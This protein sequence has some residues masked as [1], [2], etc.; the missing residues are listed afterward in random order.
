MASHS[1]QALS[2]FLGYASI[3][4]WLGAQFPQVL[5]NARRQSVDGLA[6]PF[7]LN[8]LLGDVTN[9][10]GCVLT[11]QLPFQTWLATYFCFVDCTLLGQYFYYRS[12]IKPSP[13][14]YLHSRSRAGS[15]V[16]TT[17][18][19][20]SAERT[21]YRAL[22]SIA[23]DLATEA[24]LAAHRPHADFYDEDDDAVDEDA[25]A[26]LADSFTSDGG[27]SVR[28]AS[29]RRK[30][31]SWG[32]GGAVPDAYP[33]PAPSRR[34]SGSL[35]TSAAASRQATRSPPAR[36]HAA[37]LHMT[38]A[39]PEAEG[40]EAL[41]ARGRSLSRPRAEA[42]EGDRDEWASARPP[43]GSSRASRKGATMVFMGVWALVGVGTL[44]GVGRGVAEA[45]LAAHTGRVLARADAVMP[46]VVPVAFAEAA[47]PYL[48]PPPN[49]H[50]DPSLVFDG[51]MYREDPEEEP[52]LEHVIGRISAWTCTTLYLTS[53][54]PQI[55]KNFVR[56]SVEGLSMYLFI[57]A[58]LGNFFYVAS[59]LTSPK[60]AQA[61]PLAS[62]YLRESIPYL[63]GSGGTLMFDVTIVTQSWLYRP[64]PHPRGRRSTRTLHEE[65]A[66]LLAADATGADD[67]ITPSRRRAG[68]S[69]SSDLM[70]E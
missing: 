47:N 62:A 19:R 24:A 30:T 27:R 29:A 51:S 44:A 11:R 41:A 31:V 64:S 40:A 65:E 2:D 17:A 8:W 14:P 20:L 60:L 7:L 53:R 50:A 32:A 45:G 38:Q 5:E 49:V 58:F 43:R 56:K 18:R 48:S 39:A 57:F 25:L 54:L 35:G 52:S 55:W 16:A 26:R 36:I 67:A 46:E 63:L 68:V 42:E 12:S 4:C 22:S 15:L 10:I 13:S 70:G 1:S 21:H 66:G 69:G 33:A 37:A 34:R 28:S 59:I 61:A 9:L 23:A 6:L 3:T